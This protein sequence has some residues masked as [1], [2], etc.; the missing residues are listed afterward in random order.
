[1]AIY[2][3]FVSRNGAV[4][5]AA[6]YIGHAGRLFYDSDNGVI[7]LSDGATPGGV[8]I[9]YNIAT[10]TTIG[11][12]KAGAGANVASDGTLTIDTSGLPLSIGNLL[13]EDTTIKTLQSNRDLFVVS[14]GTG[15]VSLIGEIH[16]YKPNG[17]P[18]TEQP[19]FRA[20]NDGQIRIL[21]PV[22][23]P[24]EGG[25]E[26]IGSAAGTYIPPGAPGTMLHMTGNPGVA[27]RV[28]LDGNANYASFVARRFNGNVASPTQVLANQD[29][30]RI[31]ATAATDAGVG[32]VALAQ[33]QFRALEDQTT[34]AQGSSINL[35]VTPVGSPASS[36][37][38]VANVTVAN[39]VGATKFTT[40]G[41]VTAGNVTA[42]TGTITAATGQFTNINSSFQTINAN[43]GAFHTYANLSFNS[44]AT[45][46]NANTAAYLT[47]ATGNI[48]AGNVTVTNLITAKN[49]NG[50]ARNAGT[51]G[52]AG[53]LTIDFATDHN[54]LVTLTTTATIAFTNI[55]AGKTVTVL[56][57]NDT[58][59]NRTITTGVVDGNTSGG[60]ATP[61]VNDGRTGVFVYRTFGTA[62]TD[63][64]CEINH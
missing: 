15:N 33:I 49:F 24:I 22:E 44:L 47:T 41:N 17:F 54:V 55:T 53:T 35:I 64:Y 12:I 36:R 1:M 23:D 43:V 14:N 28:Y 4:S 34:T 50:Q 10:E 42:T 18:P 9:P 45:G 39:G 6:T 62:S 61:N 27:A 26:I 51:L 31:N 8:F 48:S 16:F 60:D 52:A 32:N 46:A 63:V 21:V 11:G 59:A 25:V 29:V 7:K 58:G 40:T 3:F 19:Y 5:N 57:K 2:D 56:L 13:I 20:K 30:F 37:V 38:E